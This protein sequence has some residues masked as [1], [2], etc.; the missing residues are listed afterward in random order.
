M[1]IRP[2]LALLLC[3]NNGSHGTKRMPHA[4]DELTVVSAPL[5]FSLAIAN[6]HDLFLHY[7]PMTCA[8]Q[9]RVVFAGFNHQSF[10]AYPVSTHNVLSWIDANTFEVLI[11]S[12]VNRLKFLSDFVFCKC[13]VY[14]YLVSV[15]HVDFRS[16]N[17]LMFCLQSIV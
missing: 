11:Q 13:L 12:L 3:R 17:G 10:R 14:T 9:L 1:A 8:Q 16:P 15:F 6:P 7:P 2:V 4:K 5:I